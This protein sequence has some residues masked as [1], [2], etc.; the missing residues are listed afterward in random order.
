MDNRI[1]QLREE[2]GL[3]QEELADKLSNSEKGLTARMIS[4]Y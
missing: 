4:Y 1:K 2:L 3:T